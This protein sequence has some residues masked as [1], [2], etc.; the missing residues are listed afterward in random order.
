MHCD[1]GYCLLYALAG[2]GAYAAF[3]F[4]YECGRSP[5]RILWSLIFPNKDPLSVRYGPWAVITGSSDGIGKEYAIN[6]AGKGM[7]VFLMART[8][9]KLKEVAEEIRSQSSVEVK[10]LAV[11][12]SKG[13]EIYDTIR[14][15][16]SGHVVG[17]LVNNVGMAHQTPMDFDRLLKQDLL[18]SISVNVQA[19]VMMTHMLLPEMKRRRRG[20]IVNMSS[21]GGLFS[22]PFGSIYGASKAFLCSFSTALSEELRGT[23]VECQL[24]IPLFILTNLTKHMKTTLWWS[25]LASRVDHFTKF[26]VFTIGRTDLTTGFWTHGLELTFLRLVTSRIVTRGTYIALAP[27]RNKLYG[28][29]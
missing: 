3:L 9:S 26:A 16:L 8:E 14:R 15:A 5:V 12:F 10:W 27:V 7:N 6:L 18:K 28:K 4:L 25:A 2:V 13:P 29:T 20:M 21:A 19:A 24:V 11:D 17:I 1:L 22:M 23:G